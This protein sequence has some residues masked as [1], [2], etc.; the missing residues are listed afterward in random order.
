MKVLPAMPIAI[1]EFP[2]NDEIALFAEVYDRTS[3]TPHRVDIVTTVR[4]ADGTV[5]FNA[6]DE[7]DSSELGGAR[8]S[9]GHALRIPVGT[10]PVGDYVL[11]LEARS[12]AGN[13]DPAVREV[14]FRVV[15]PIP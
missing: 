8:G 3:S 12:R 5:Y 14:P 9:Y 11:T 1:R 13:Q 7:R 10:M 2:Q 15:P 6:Q 4:G